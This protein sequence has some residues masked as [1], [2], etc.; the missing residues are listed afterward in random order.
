M[1]LSQA[2]YLTSQKLSKVG[3]DYTVIEAELLLQH[4]LGISKTQLYTDRSRALTPVE[5][6]RLQEITQRRL[7]REPS[8]YILN[9]REFYG[10][11]FYIDQRVLIPRPETEILVEKAIE[12]ASRHFT[13]KNLTIADVGT[14]SGVIAITLA[15]ALPLAIVYATDVS[16]ASL[17]VA[18]MNCRR[19][20]VNDQVKLLHGNLL[21]P[22]PQPIDMIIT[23][24]PYIKETELKM[25]SPE[26]VNFEPLTALTG[27][28]DGLDKIR[29]LLAQIPDKVCP[30]G[31]FLMEIGQGQAQAVTSLIRGCLPEA[32]IE[33]VPDLSNIDRVVSVSL[34]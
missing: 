9:Q 4:A 17:E 15:I 3:I 5:T 19:H 28:K 10:I 18:G 2:I 6:D 29:S 11:D 20:K 25:L 27:G 32:S 21:E 12:S 26:I 30:R 16:T 33:L 34:V 13:K 31:C 7:C 23:N 22:L 1:T 24:L 14:G 8:A